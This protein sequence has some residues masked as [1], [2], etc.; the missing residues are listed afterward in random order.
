MVFLGRTMSVRRLPRVSIK[1]NVITAA[2]VVDFEDVAAS[3]RIKKSNL[4]AVSAASPP[5]QKSGARIWASAKVRKY[6][7]EAAS[8]TTLSCVGMACPGSPTLCAC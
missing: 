3:L 6:V 1:K 5:V 8:A 7:Q 2:T 4:Y